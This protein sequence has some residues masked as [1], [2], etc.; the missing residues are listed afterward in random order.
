[1]F[2]VSSPTSPSPKTKPKKSG[3]KGAKNKIKGGSPRLS[4][5]T[6]IKAFKKEG[7]KEEEEEEKIKNKKRHTS[8]LFP[9]FPFT[10]VKW[11]R[12]LGERK[13]KVVQKAK[14]LKRGRGF[15]TLQ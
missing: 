9:S 11:G 2:Y 15:D 3:H 12:N 10:S 4:G 8:T 7:L 6:K 1:M 14:K 13:Q 5:M